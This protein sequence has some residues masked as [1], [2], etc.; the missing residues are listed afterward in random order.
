[1][2]IS[3]EAEAGRINNVLET[4]RGIDVRMVAMNSNSSEDIQI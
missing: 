3:V 4:F 1:M 2:A